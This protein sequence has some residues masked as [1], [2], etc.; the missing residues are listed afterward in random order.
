MGLLFIIQILQ[1]INIGKVEVIKME[2]LSVKLNHF[3]VSSMSPVLSA[4]INHTDENNFE[5]I[6]SLGAKF[7][8]ESKED[9]L[10]LA[11]LCRDKDPML[12]GWVRAMRGLNSTAREKLVKNLLFNHLIYGGHI[13][14]QKGQEYSTHI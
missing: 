12:T 6:F 8:K 4:L 3:I 11:Q 13:R 14:E 10:K 5:K 9:L 7:A 1:I 2:N